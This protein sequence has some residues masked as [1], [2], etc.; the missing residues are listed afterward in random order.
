L[1]KLISSLT[2]ERHLGRQAAS[3]T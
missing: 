1:K 2:W 3:S